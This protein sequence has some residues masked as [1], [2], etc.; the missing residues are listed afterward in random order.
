M[1][2]EVR[3][4]TNLQQIDH[5]RQ[6][7]HLPPECGPSPA[8]IVNITADPVSNAVILSPA[9]KTVKASTNIRIGKPKMK[10]KMVPIDQAKTPD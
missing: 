5:E 7:Q 6:F 3:T 1:A 8:K 4:G 2:S 9:K 10:V